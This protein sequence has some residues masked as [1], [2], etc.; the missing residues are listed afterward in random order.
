VNKKQILVRKQQKLKIKN[1]RINSWNESFE[2]KRYQKKSFKTFLTFFF[3]PWLSFVVEFK[4][5][6]GCE[7]RKFPEKDRLSW[8]LNM[9]SRTF[10]LAE[11]NAAFDCGELK[12]FSF[13]GEK[14]SW[15]NCNS[16]FWDCCELL[17]ALHADLVITEWLPT[18]AMD[19]F[20]LDLDDFT[21]D[22][23]F[24]EELPDWG[25]ENKDKDPSLSDTTE[26]LSDT[27]LVSETGCCV[28]A[29][30]TSDRVRVFNSSIS[31]TDFIW[32]DITSLLSFLSSKV[33]LVKSNDTSL[34]TREEPLLLFEP[35]TSWELV[36]VCEPLTPWDFGTGDP[37]SLC[38]PCNPLSWVSL[39]STP[40][41]PSSQPETLLVASC[42]E[43]SGRVELDTM[44]MTEAVEE[45]CLLLRE[46]IGVVSSLVAMNGASD[47]AGS[48]LILFSLAAGK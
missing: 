31:I 11:L 39:F 25:L 15:L 30:D 34:G 22:F 41:S 1:S 19:D 46:L 28:S 38:D 40:D 45:G 3:V 33:T 20:T 42:C 4:L 26:F 6:I 18:E 24:L 2:D 17:I 32:G 36:T 29:S 8:L 5:D 44:L 13:V 47:G 23:L 43:C 7:V 21:W 37:W 9:F 48:L 12:P 27:D 35:R 10:W 16:E 14:M